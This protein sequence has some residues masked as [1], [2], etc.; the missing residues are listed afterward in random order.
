[1]ASEVIA[2]WLDDGADRDAVVVL[3]RV[4][5]SLLPVQ[6]ALVARGIP[7]RSVLT[8]DLLN[9][10][11][12]RAALAYLR[13]GLNPK[14]MATADVEEVLRRPPRKLAREIVARAKS[15]KSI[16]GLGRARRGLNAWQAEAIT[17]A[18]EDIEAVRDAIAKGMPAVVHAIKEWVGL[19]EAMKELDS[20]RDVADRSTHM[21]DLD[22][23]SQLAVL[24]HDPRTFEAWLR[25][26][27]SSSSQDD[28]V[29]L[30]TVHRVKGLEW[31]YVVVFG[32]REGLFPHRLS[33]GVLSS[34]EEERRV[35]HV[36]I[37]RARRRAVA[38]ADS[39]KP[40]RFVEEILGAAPTKPP[41]KEASAK[42]RSRPRA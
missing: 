12:M 41:P 28:G 13:C 3:T 8:L 2:E 27:L 6:A 37:T 30:S 34:V 40:S 1:M 9:R 18:M 10:T 21:D 23:L 14:A 31:D 19:G 25:E 16:A 20:A 32:A 11:G 4:N 24:H 42:R 33:S 5:S 17:Q 36:A 15:A 39:A 22:A 38:I 35:F 26:L 29:L 7:V